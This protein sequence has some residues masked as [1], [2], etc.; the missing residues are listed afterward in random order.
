LATSDADD[1]SVAPFARPLVSS[2]YSVELRFSNDQ[3]TYIEHTFAW[4]HAPFQHHFHSNIPSIQESVPSK[5]LDQTTSLF[6]PLKPTTI[7]Q[8]PTTPPA[9]STEAIIGIVALIVGLPPTLL[10]LWHCI[11]RCMGLPK[12]S[13]SSDG[14]SGK[15]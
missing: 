3:M 9:M 11:K 10:L 12:S 6:G 4:F 2:K 13:E 14:E 5:Y 15:F 1:P 7:L 8:A